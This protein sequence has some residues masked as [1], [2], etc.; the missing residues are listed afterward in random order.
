MFAWRETMCFS[1]VL[2]HGTAEYGMLGDSIMT[3]RWPGNV[4][5]DAVWLCIHDH[6]WNV[7]GRES[8]PLAILLCLSVAIL[9]DSCLWVVV[10][11]SWVCVPVSLQC[12]GHRHQCLCV[13]LGVEDC[14]YKLANTVTKYVPLRLSMWL[15]DSVWPK[16]C[17]GV[18]DTS[19]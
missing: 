8:E 16:R 3:D 18:T 4:D 2:W 17:V 12:M 6:F 11:M 5:T 7:Y 9:G 19:G 1:V 15:C 14:P 10:C 13:W